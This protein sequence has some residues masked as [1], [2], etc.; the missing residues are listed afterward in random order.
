[1]KK[2]REKES[3][4]SDM[5]GSWRRGMK[6]LDFSKGIRG[7]DVEALTKEHDRGPRAIFPLFAALETP[8]LLPVQLFFPL[9][10]FPEE[11]KRAVLRQKPTF[12]PWIYSIGVSHSGL[13]HK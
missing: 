1:V 5:Q 10:H 7:L 12:H 4:K 9:H 3:Q 8:F 11:K 6:K 13:K 2:E